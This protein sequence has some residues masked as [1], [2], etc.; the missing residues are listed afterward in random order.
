MDSA[1]R[2]VVQCIPCPQ[3]AGQAER[4]KKGKGEGS[5]NQAAAAPL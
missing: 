1:L 3:L 2:E 5:V 4:D